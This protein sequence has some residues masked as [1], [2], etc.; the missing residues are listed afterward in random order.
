MTGLERKSDIVNM[1]AY[2][3]L[4]VNTHDRAWNPDMIVFDNHR[5]AC[6]LVPASCPLA[7]LGQC[8]C[9]QGHNRRRWHFMY[10]LCWS[11]RYI[12]VSLSSENLAITCC[13]FDS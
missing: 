6:L 13:L 7:A 4:F 9:G 11:A 12:C 2:A 8:Q 3:P 1:A 5:Q 10:S